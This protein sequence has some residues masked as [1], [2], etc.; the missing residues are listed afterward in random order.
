MFTLGV[1]Q[2]YSNSRLRYCNSHYII[3]K[4]CNCH[5]TEQKECGIN[6]HSFAWLKIYNSVY[7]AGIF[8]IQLT[9]NTINYF[10]SHGGYAGII[11][12]H[13]IKRIPVYALKSH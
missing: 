10:R 8:L 12:C 13:P 3:V 4:H 2:C 6:L 9:L 5:S 7:M 1:M 11:R